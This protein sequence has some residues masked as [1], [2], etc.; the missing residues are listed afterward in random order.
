ME[1]TE[2]FPEADVL[3]LAE[4]LPCSRARWQVTRLYNSKHILF[5]G[6]LLSND[7]E[8]AAPDVIV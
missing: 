5:A 8:L 7:R 1:G 2:L 3:V 4:H 6:M